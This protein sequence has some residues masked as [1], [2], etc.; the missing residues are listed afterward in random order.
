[1][2]FYAIIQ[3]IKT[4][5]TDPSV[6]RALE[7]LLN[8]LDI[9]SLTA[10]PCVQY[11]IQL[12][13]VDIAF[14]V[15]LAITT[16]VSI[17]LNNKSIDLLTLLID[18]GTAPFDQQTASAFDPIL[19]KKDARIEHSIIQAAIKCQRSQSETFSSV[20]HAVI[21]G[22]SGNPPTKNHLL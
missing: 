12:E 3:Y 11:P 16:N 14:L 4:I 21:Y 13:E 10:D 22:L 19:G 17:P 9:D 8:K 7:C 20:A 15:D 5:T 1:M 18:L 6:F 2:L